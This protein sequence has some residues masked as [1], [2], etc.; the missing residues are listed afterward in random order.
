MPYEKR[1]MISCLLEDFTYEKNV[2]GDPRTYPSK[3]AVGVHVGMLWPAWVRWKSRDYAIRN[4]VVSPVGN[5]KITKVRFEVMQTGWVSNVRSTRLTV[6]LNGS[7]LV[8]QNITI[9]SWDVWIQK[10]ISIDQEVTPDGV[11][12]VEVYFYDDLTVYADYYRFV[13]MISIVGTYMSEKAPGYGDITARVTN[14]ETGMPVE[15]ASVYLLQDSRIVAAKK[16]DSSGIAKFTGVM[17]GG[18]TIKVIKS[19]FYDL[20]YSIVLGAG[21]SIIVELP[22]APVPPPWWME[23]ISKNWIWVLGGAVAIIGTYVIVKR[24]TGVS[25]VYVIREKLAR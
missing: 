15:G 23:W 12:K 3:Q 7:K 16:T 13:G 8:D 1:L 20:E 18:Y 11:L 14:A 25:P 17:E 4:Y 22:I 2:F 5:V 19:G 6:Y 21:E 10:E 24:V 9:E